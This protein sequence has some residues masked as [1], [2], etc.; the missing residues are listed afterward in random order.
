LLHEDG[1]FFTANATRAKT[2]DGFILQLVFVGQQGIGKFSEL[3]QAPVDRAFES[4]FVDF[5]VVALAPDPQ[6]GEW[7]D[8]SC[9]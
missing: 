1:C 7:W 4:A 6:Q 2:D 9:E 3:G 8:G 5:V